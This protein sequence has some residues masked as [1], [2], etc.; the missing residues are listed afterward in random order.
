MEIN[1]KVAFFFIATM[2]AGIVIA[3]IYHRMVMSR[4]SKEHRTSL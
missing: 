4:R 1:I 2:I 3:Y